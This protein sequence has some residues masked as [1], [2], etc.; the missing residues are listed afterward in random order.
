VR[1]RKGRLAA[2]A[3][4]IWLPIVSGDVTLAS[5]Q[6]SLCLSDYSDALL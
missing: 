3:G 6:K 4:S 1:D 2:K 5:S